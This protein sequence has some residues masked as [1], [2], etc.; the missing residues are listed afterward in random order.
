MNKKQLAVILMLVCL[1]FVLVFIQRFFDDSFRQ[2]VLVDSNMGQL[3][4]Y[5]VDN[6]GISFSLPDKWSTEERDSNNYSLYKVEF[7]DSENSIM[8]YIELIKCN[9]D[10]RVVAQK[11]INNMTLSHD[12][13]KIEN[14]R[15]MNRNGIRVQYKTKINKGY[16]FVNTNYYIALKD[17]IIG[18]CTFICRENSYKDNLRFVYNSIVDS[19]TLK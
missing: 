15:S 5:N 19:I 6:K 12:T 4:N 8:G 10:I 9:E 16:S 11:D 7:K 13:E 1:M 14:Y 17:G 2:V 3:K 18:K